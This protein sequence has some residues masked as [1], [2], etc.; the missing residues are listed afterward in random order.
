[1]K[2]ICAPVSVQAMDRLNFNR[3]IEGDLIEMY[4]NDSEYIR[5][6][7]LGYFSLI[8]KCL[9]KM[10]DDFEDEQIYHE[11]LIEFLKLTFKFLEA[12]KGISH[13]LKKIIDLANLA[14]EKNTAV[15][16]FF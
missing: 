9:N 3:N 12:N 14:L 16:F 4:L 15:F 11:D 13:I 6:N 5:L 1:M 2:V 8:N 10:I 7:E